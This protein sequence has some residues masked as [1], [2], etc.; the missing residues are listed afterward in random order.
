MC[1]LYNAG[2]QPATA[3]LYPSVS[4]PVSRGTPG[5]ASHV[6]WD[7]SSE[8]SVADFSAAQRSGENVV[9]FDLSRG[10]DAFLAGHNIDGRVLFPATGYLTLVWR[11]MA[12]LC[13]RRI[14]E[15]AVVLEG[16]QFRRATILSQDGPVRFLVSVLDGSGEFEVREG[17][18]VA[19]SGTV[20]L[21]EDP[22]AERLPP[23]ALQAP[24]PTPGDA[25]LPPLDGDDI[26]KELRL[27]GYNYGGLFRGIRSSDARGTQGRLAWDD[28]WISF[29]DTMLQF[30]IIGVDTRE[31]YLPTRLQRAVIDPRAHA[32]AVAQAQDGALPVRMARDVDVV[33][34]G[35]VELRG[36]KTSL[37]P[38]RAN[39]Q[40]APKLEKYVFVPYDN[41]AV[42]TEDTSR[43]KRDALL[44]SLQLVLENAGALRLRALEAALDRPAEALLLPA[45]LPLLAAEPMVRVDAALA[46]GD[47]QAAYAALQELD[48]QVLSGEPAFGADGVQL[49]CAGDVLARAGRGLDALAATLAP[50]GALLLEEPLRA[51]D[52]PAAKDL[53]RRHDLQLISRQV[54]AIS[55]CLRSYPLISN[56]TSRKRW[57]RIFFVF[58]N[59]II[60]CISQKKCLY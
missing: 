37:A 2:C 8:W 53:L 20:R 60:H 21:S 39:A 34:A 15:T 49:A 1:R 23:A 25:P 29:M 7:H 10:D 58:K 4:W 22:A 32:A 57:L 24:A 45:A 47:A 27:R 3:R 55:A 56:C 28:N 54:F 9:E 51:L 14:E 11:T 41:A 40:G 31:L 30:G 26:Y 43:S 38:R 35:G 44:A 48:V 42:G 19:V 52:D 36:V 17:G 5:L 12:K 46:A 33:A 16:V 59:S 13:N 18:A 6:R 50:N